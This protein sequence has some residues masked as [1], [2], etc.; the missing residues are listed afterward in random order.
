M[1][2]KHNT[3]SRKEAIVMLSLFNKHANLQYSP[4]LIFSEGKEIVLSDTEL[5]SRLKY[6][7]FYQADIELLREIKPLILEVADEVIT[8][9]LN[10][11]ISF[12]ELKEIATTHSTYEMLAKVFHLY[13]DSLFSSEIDDNYIKQ[14]KRIGMTH[15][16]STLPVGWFLATFPLFKSLLFPQIVKYYQHNHE[17]MV[18]TILAVSNAMNFDAQIIVETYNEAKISEIQS[19]NA[20]N[21]SLQEELISISQQ[22]AA[23]IQETEASTT[24]T[25][26]KAARVGKEIEQTLATSKHVDTLTNTNASDM[27]KVEEMLLKLMKEVE[28]SRETINLLEE[29]AYQINKMTSEIEKVSDQT[30]L[31]ALNASIEAAR[32]GEHGKG[33]SVVA[34]EV[35]KLAEQSKK[36]STEIIT[37]I[38]LSNDNISNLTKTMNTIHVSTDE[39]NSSIKTVQEGFT[40]IKQEMTQNIHRFSNNKDEVDQIIHSIMEI[41]DAQATLTQLA[42]L[43]TEKA[44]TLQTSNR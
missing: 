43:L 4:S 8:Q 12:P 7:H 16:K 29:N 31:L 38:S 42:S 27:R 21:V 10:H 2:N 36:M 20:A 9:I 41:N 26:E 34:S 30:N 40:A 3:T 11:I 19:L 15:N 13:L 25:S 35:R 39:S 44:E 24:E 32:A 5:A 14:R 18:N 22:L 23:T 1:L 6:I 28:R 33:F 17:K 37:L